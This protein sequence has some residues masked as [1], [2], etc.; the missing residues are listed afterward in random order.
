MK[1]VFERPR[2]LKDAVYHYCPGCGHSIIHRL[3]AE[4]IDELGIRGK[5]IGVP[6]AGCAVLAYNYF[7]VDMAEAPHGRAIAVATGIKRMLPDRVVFTYQGDGDIAAIGTAEA[8][9]AANRGER[10]TVVFVNNGVY[11]MTGGQMAP[12][13]ILG[14]LS[15]TT[16][17]GRQE[18]RDGFPLDLSEMLAITRGSV[19]IERC[20]VNSP[21]NI[22]R[23]KKALKKA[24]KVQMKDLGFSLVE[25]V[26]QCPTNWKMKPIDACR[27][28][29]ETVTK[30][31]PL[32][33]IKDEA[34]G[35]R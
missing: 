25:I 22:I 8:V 5:T 24:F 14:Q 15:T 4:V 10:I 21:K 30:V 18:L 2:S 6:P 17:Q 33:V 16:P 32:K 7:D 35:I 19:Y 12:T 27:Y 28:I 34:K 29:D 11:G 26:S 31:Y 9:H 1:K 3:I 20:A 13:T 23:A